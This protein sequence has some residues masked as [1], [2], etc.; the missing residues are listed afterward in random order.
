MEIML[1]ENIF[2]ALLGAVFGVVL[3]ITPRIWTQLKHVRTARLLRLR[4]AATKSGAIDEW[5]IRYYDEHQVSL[6]YSS[7]NGIGKYVPVLHD[8]RLVFTRTLNPREDWPLAVEPERHTQFPIDR[9]IIDY[10]RRLGAV[11]FQSWRKSLYLDA[12]EVNADGTPTILA[13]PCEYFEIATALLG[14]E[15][16]TF[17]TTIRATKRLT[18]RPTK[19]PLRDGHRLNLPLNGN[20]QGMPLSVGSNTVLIIRLGNRYQVAIQTRA[21]TVITSPGAKAVIPNYGFEPR[22]FANARSA[23]GVVFYNFI[24]E[25]LEELFDYEEI[26]GRN[27]WA[28]RP[29]WILEFPEAKTLTRALDEGRFSISYLGTGIECMSGTATIALLALVEDDDVAAELVRQLKP[30]YEVAP[31]TTSITPVEFVDIDDPRLAGWHQDG[32]FQ[33][34]TAFALALALEHLRNPIAAR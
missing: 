31:A 6:F 30:N 33:A 15:E 19:T 23:Y 5:L 32:L 27:T 1:A 12:I 10:R 9:R 7:I 2:Y 21:E 11:L 26:I 4:R 17:R 18:I 34:S 22:E 13:R 28:R 29:D 24:R 14:L 20:R 25:Y 3:T 16:E 8:P